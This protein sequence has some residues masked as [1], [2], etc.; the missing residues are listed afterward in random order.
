MYY[1]ENSQASVKSQHGNIMKMNLHLERSSL[2][3]PVS[4]DGA[5]H[6]PPVLQLSH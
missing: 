1:P 6:V 5:V 2:S 4:E 3:L